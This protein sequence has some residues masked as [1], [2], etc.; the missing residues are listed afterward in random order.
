MRRQNQW[1]LAFIRQRPVIHGLRIPANDVC[2]GI[3]NVTAYGTYMTVR[4]LN[5]QTDT[6]TIVL[7]AHEGHDDPPSPRLSAGLGRGPSPP[8]TPTCV[9]PIRGQHIIEAYS[10]SSETNNMNKSSVFIH[11]RSA[12]NTGKHIRHHNNI[13]THI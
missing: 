4:T 6:G 5:E 2:F 9:D 7:T 12:F 11:G 3:R 13:H 8:S 10:G 1:A